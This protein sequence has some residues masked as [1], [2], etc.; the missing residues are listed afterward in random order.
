MPVLAFFRG[1]RAGA[2]RLAGAVEMR[3]ARRQLALS[4]TPMACEAAA[5]LWLR[6]RLQS[7]YA[8]LPR[9]LGPERPQSVPIEQGQRRGLA[10]RA[11][12]TRADLVF[13]G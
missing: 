4:F 8:R 9:A 12:M 6:T 3:N 11:G 13:R 7:G 5:R 1:R 2:G 10:S